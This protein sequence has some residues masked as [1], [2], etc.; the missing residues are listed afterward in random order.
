MKR[1]FI[2]LHIISIVYKILALL[3]FIGMIAGIA[4]VLL[5]AVT[6][7]T[8]ESK[9]PALGG[10]L[11]TGIVG[12]ITLLATAQL[13]DLLISLEMNTRATTALLQRMGRVMQERL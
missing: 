9:L 10:L 8:L 5:D 7:P 3:A 13:L 1:R 4:L 12:A 6:F 2:A 11:G